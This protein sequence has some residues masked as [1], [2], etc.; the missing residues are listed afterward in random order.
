[1]TSPQDDKNQPDE[2]V[3]ARKL[4]PFERPSI[5]VVRFTMARS[6]DSIPPDRSLPFGY[7]IEPWCEPLLPAFAAAMAVSFSDSTDLEVYPRL[8]SREGCLDFMKE[9]FSLPEFHTGASWLVFFNREPCAFIITSSTQVKGT[10]QIKVVGVAPRHR[11]IK[12][13]ETLCYRAMW[14]L[15]DRRFSRVIAKVNRPNHSAVR[16]FR[17]LGFQVESSQEYM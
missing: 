8:G 17:S 13:G 15:R 7:R 12:V 9:I 3:K 2:S 6:L 1:M 16:F 5:E 11:R 10:G 4:G 14:A